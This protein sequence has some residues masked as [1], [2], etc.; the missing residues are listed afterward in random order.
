MAAASDRP[1]SGRYPDGARASPPPMPTRPVE[2]GPP[3]L[4]SQRRRAKRSAILL[5]LVAGTFYFGFMVLTYFRS[6]H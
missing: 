3:T 5:A 2:S 6:T 4:E 1:A